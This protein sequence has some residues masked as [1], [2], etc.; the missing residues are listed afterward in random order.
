M[1]NVCLTCSALLIRLFV[2]LLH[3]LLLLLCV[4]TILVNKEDQIGIISTFRLPCSGV[5]TGEGD[6]EARAP[7]SYQAGS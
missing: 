3:F 2:L 7:N 1:L 6:K 5:A 4:S